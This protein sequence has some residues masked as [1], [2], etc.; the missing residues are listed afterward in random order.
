VSDEEGLVL[1]GAAGALLF[2]MGRMGVGCRTCELIVLALYISCGSFEDKFF[3]FIFV[4]KTKK[5]FCSFGP[6]ARGT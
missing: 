1:K 3:K 5:I 6:K 4:W 2:V